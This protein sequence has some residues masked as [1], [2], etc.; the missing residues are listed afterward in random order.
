MKVT[1]QSPAI[2]AHHGVAVGVE[3]HISDDLGA[4]YIKRGQARAVG[5]SDT[6]AKPA[7]KKK[8]AA[9]KKAAK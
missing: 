3:V 1:L 8:K 4:M 7:K 5:K 2:A 6:P 9:S